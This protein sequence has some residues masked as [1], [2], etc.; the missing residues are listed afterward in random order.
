MK[1]SISTSRR[2]VTGMATRLAIV[3]ALFFALAR[4]SQAQLI[5]SQNFNTD[6]STNWAVNFSYTGGALFNSVSNSLYNFN[7][8]YT[9]AGIP[10]APHSAQFGSD[11]IHHGLKLS[12]VYTNVA[13]AKG[14][15][16][17][18]G[19]SASPTNFSVSQNFVMHAD[20]WVNVNCG[21]YATLNTSNVTG[22]SYATSPHNGTASTVLYGCGYGTAGTTATTPGV[23]DAIFVGVT[24]DNG[25][26]AQMR[27]YGPQI[28]PVNAQS[29]FQDFCY[30]STG[31]ITPGF[32]GDPL[33]YNTANGTRNWIGSTAN[34]PF[35]NLA[36]NPVTGLLW[37]NTF[38]P[39]VVP[40][41]Q[42]I[43]YP[44]QTNNASCPGL[45]TF[46]WHDVS[47]E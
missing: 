21:A 14:S 13:T 32:P 30:Q 17:T 22:A 25:S 45:P 36:T 24:T 34:P 35:N 3:G 18:A 15:A 44:Q 7:F 40:L 39:V 27:M 10:I 1:P 12:A 16:V 37:S 31:T 11:V 6:D 19:M 41:A 43:L 47:V 4:S 26:A 9:T 46:A 33:I 42:Q 29:S 2:P 38:P 8:D 28:T 20:M 23:T 5:Y